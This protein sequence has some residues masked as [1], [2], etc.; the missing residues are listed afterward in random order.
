VIGTP[1]VKSKNP[2]AVAEKGGRKAWL[3]PVSIRWA[4]HP[5]LLDPFLVS[6]SAMPANSSQR[7]PGLDLHQAG[8]DA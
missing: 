2:Q 3:E 1:R 5:F 6:P 8:R 4:R 7:R